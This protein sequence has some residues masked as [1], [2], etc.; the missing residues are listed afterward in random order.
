MPNINRNIL[1]LA[2]LFALLVI[3]ISSL[4]TLNQKNN[5]EILVQKKQVD[6]LLLPA[7]EPVSE[8]LR[9]Y[10]KLEQNYIN[11]INEIDSIADNDDINISILKENL[12]Q[13]MELIKADKAHIN[14]KG[15]AEIK[16]NAKQLEDMLNMSRE[17][18]EE[19]LLEESGNTDKLTIDNRKLTL[20]F[21]K[22]VLNY[23]LEKK[24]N[25]NLND[26]VA[27][28]ENKINMLKEEGEAPENEIK[29]LERQKAESK[30]KIQEN[31]RMLKNQAIKIQ[32][33][34]EIIRKVNIDCYFYYEKG[35]LDEESTI[36]LTNEGISEKY[37]K[38]FV[39]KKPD[40]FVEFRILNFFF[41]EDIK[42]LELTFYN[43]LNIE[44]YNVSKAINLGN[45]KIIIPNKNF[46]PGKYSI[47]LKAGDENL[48]L[49]ER[50]K[51]KISN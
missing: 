39:R 38:Y 30:K 15:D 24:I 34:G 27:N 11:L 36:Y 4:I 17:V 6:T 42:K 29:S 20:K 44:V 40:I 12:K 22:L 37:L 32:E 13:I 31:N 23:N 35:N 49:D 7:I 18:L 43:S 26:N 45:Y 21:R 10:E 25:V 2:I 19:C 3:V 8:L 50:Y 5:K 41:P 1:K 14:S 51:F 46:S 47:K 28:L 9:D 16:S 33:V 48:L